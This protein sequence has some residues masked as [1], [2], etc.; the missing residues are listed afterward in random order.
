MTSERRS[1]IKKLTRNY[2]KKENS[3]D[4]ACKDAAEGK[5]EKQDKPAGSSRHGPLPPPSAEQEE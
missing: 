5:Q 1:L 3:P 2:R 4:G